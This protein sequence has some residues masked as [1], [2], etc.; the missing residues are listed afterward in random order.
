MKCINCKV[1][2]KK[3]LIFNQCPACSRP[4][5]RI[6]SFDFKEQ[7]DGTLHINT[8]GDFYIQELFNQ[9]PSVL[10]NN[11]TLSIQG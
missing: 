1:R 5:I 4:N 2:Y 6:W 7:E 8:Y 11:V 10:I 9:T 3:D